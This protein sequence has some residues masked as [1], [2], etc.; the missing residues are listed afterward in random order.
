MHRTG[1]Y[2]VKNFTRY[3]LPLFIWAATIFWLSSLSFSH[4]KS[5]FINADKLVHISIF[6]VFCWFSRRALFFQNASQSIKKWSLWGSFIL[7]CLYGYLDEVHQLYVPG[8][9]YD[10]FDMLADAIGAFFF[11]VLFLLYNRS[12]GEQRGTG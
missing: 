1:W 2:C 9:T 8:R 7:T 6:F 5:P 4:V 11:V 3:Q 12:K 10:Y